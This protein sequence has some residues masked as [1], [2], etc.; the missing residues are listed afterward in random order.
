MK[1]FRV[2]DMH[3]M[4]CVERITKLFQEEELEFRIYLEEKIVEVDGGEKEAERGKEALEDLGFT[5][6]EF[7]G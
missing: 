7:K 4:K 5:P 2:E 1:K 6:E 3:C